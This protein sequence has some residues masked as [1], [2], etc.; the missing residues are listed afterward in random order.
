MAKL[1][2]KGGMTFGGEYAVK[3]AKNAVLPM[4]AASILTEEK[5]ELFGVPDITD[6]RNMLKI[7]EKLGATCLF[8][9]SVLTIN[10]VEANG[11]SVGADLAKEL[12]SSVFLLGPILARSRRAAVAYPGGCDIG[13]RPL[14]IHI[15]GLQELGVVVEEHPTDNL[16]KDLFRR[17]G[18]ACIV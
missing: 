13:V 7:I 12:R 3:A 4:I 8:D 15:K 6:I 10:G 9:N 14:D 17:A 11:F 18:D 5:C 2:V 1:L 16:C